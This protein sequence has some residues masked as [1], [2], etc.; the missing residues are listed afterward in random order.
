MAVFK[1]SQLFLFSIVFLKGEKELKCNKIFII[2]YSFYQLV[3]TCPSKTHYFHQRKT[4]FR[5]NKSKHSSIAKRLI[6]KYPVLLRKSKILFTTKVGQKLRQIH[7][8]AIATLHTPDNENNICEISILS[9]NSLRTERIY[10]Y[11]LWNG[12]DK[13]LCFDCLSSEFSKN[14]LIER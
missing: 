11:L 3:Q 8:H 6:G 9:A 7:H 2:I 12:M 14:S 13:R 4:Q 10:V 5:K 1:C